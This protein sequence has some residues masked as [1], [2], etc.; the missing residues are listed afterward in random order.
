MED[1]TTVFKKWLRGEKF[2]FGEVF[3][4]MISTASNFVSKPYLA[5]GPGSRNAAG[6]HNRAFNLDSL[7]LF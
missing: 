5:P 3:Y 4:H 2:S 1:V 6:E 7:E